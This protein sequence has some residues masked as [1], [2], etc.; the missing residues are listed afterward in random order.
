MKIILCVLL[1]L[2]CQ[3]SELEVITFVYP[4][5]INEDGSGSLQLELK[6]RMSKSSISTSFKV[7]PIARSMKSFLDNDT[8]FLGTRNQ[9][10][11][12]VSN[13]LAQV[14]FDSIDT[15]LYRNIKKRDFKVM[16]KLRDNDGED[17]LIKQFKGAKAVSVKDARQALTMVNKG[18]VDA[19][20]CIETTCD[21]ILK[22]YKLKSVV[23]SKKIYKT[24]DVG[25]IY[26]K[27]TSN[28]EIINLIEAIKE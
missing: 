21:K 5:Y 10:S 2:I 28:K 6:K 14:S 27:N 26:K 24:I 12:T 9:F 11:P 16:A 23:K 4:P 25:I 1:A 7:L 20:F 19:F 15:Y 8:L 17:R 3:A 13:K 22:E 18:R